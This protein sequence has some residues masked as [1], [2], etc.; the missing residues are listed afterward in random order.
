SDQSIPVTVRVLA[1]SSRNLTP[2]VDQGLFRKDLYYRLNIVSLRIPPLRERKQD[3][4]VLA[5]YY[6]DQRRRGSAVAHRLGVDAIHVLLTYDWP[7]DVQELESTI[8][9][10]CVKSSGPILHPID[11]PS[12]LQNVV[13]AKEAQEVMRIDARETVPVPVG[14][15]PVDRRAPAA[16]VSIADLEREAILHTIRQLHGDK[17]M[18]A[19]LLGIGKTTLYRKLKEYGIAE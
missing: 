3:V 8:D 13:V 5:E 18:A 12:Q 15:A 17:L 4:L 19:K 6:L 1:A 14:Q 11:L 7:G 2:L 10:A 16:I 9:S